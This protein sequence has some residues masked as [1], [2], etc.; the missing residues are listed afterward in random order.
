MYTPP[1]SISNEM[2]IKCM[3]ITEKLGHITSLSSFK[4]MPT[5]RHNN[6]IKSVHSSLVIEANSLSLE[7]VRDVIAG[8]TVIGPQREI[9]EVKNAY[10]AYESIKDFD[11]YNEQDLLKAHHILLNA[12]DDEAGEY[13]HHGEG[14]FQGEKLIFMAPPA[15]QVPFLM[16]DLFTWLKEDNNTPPLLKSC[17][18]HYEFVFIHPFGD[19]NGRTARLWQNVLLTKWNPLFEYIPLESSIQKYQ[20]DYYNSISLCHKN[21]N[22]NVFIEFIL[23][24]IDET[25]DD[26]LRSMHKEVHNISDQVNRLLSIMEPGIPLSA[27][28]IMVELN[29]KSKET[30]RHSY[31]NPAIDN[32][33]ITMTL[34]AKP[35][36][37]HQKY[38]KI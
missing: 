38:L 35:N 34:P 4:R 23:N 19:G 31:L 6:K 5:L 36:S 22:Y 9:L 28:E 30:L 33:L 15:S 32:G 13:R 16:K 27:H 17:I 18:F 29:I 26:V 2:L 20:S 24:V 3:S 1:Y 12:L 7:Q 10:Q 8:K 25:L 14:V 37:K 11:G 21:G